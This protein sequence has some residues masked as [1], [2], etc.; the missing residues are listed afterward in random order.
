MP[1]KPM[2]SRMLTAAGLGLMVACS[3]PLLSGAGG[4]IRWNRL[5]GLYAPA[6]E[7]LHGHHTP[8]R[9]AERP[10][11]VRPHPIPGLVTEG[12]V[13]SILVDVRPYVDRSA[14]LGRV[15]I[16]I[17]V[18]SLRLWGRDAEFPRWPEG[19][20]VSRS[21]LSGEEMCRTL[22]DHEYFTRNCG[23]RAPAL[24]VQSTL[25]VRV[26]ASSDG[27]FV[28]EEMMTH[29]AKL[30]QVMGEVGMPASAEVRTSDGYVG[31]LREVIQDDAARLVT[32]VEF[33]FATSGLSLYATGKAP[34]TNRFGQQ[35]TFDRMADQLL[36]S[37]PGTTV[38][39]GAHV[40]YALAVLLR[41]DQEK[42]LLTEATRVRIRKH[43]RMLSSALERCQAPDGSWPW[44]WP[45]YCERGSDPGGDE[46]E[47][48]LRLTMTATGHHLEWI[49]IAP[50]DCRP[51]RQAIGKAVRYTVRTWPEFMGELK[52]DWHLYTVASH[53]ARALWLISG[54]EPCRSAAARQ[55]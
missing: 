1:I 52:D 12:E 23:M 48:R 25:G 5:T 17:L 55:E 54:F 9:V 8:F 51:S 11:V 2:V 37:R 47:D 46:E 27:S 41:V 35:Y 15:P 3:T 24:L 19:I 32:G 49:A 36:G 29:F 26:L 34:W 13:R 31:T 28:A 20:H 14:L 39:G 40:P 16:A 53:A 43:F 10:A 45:A 22:L 44:R 50:D 7:G 30:T 4:P 38:C 18:H 21:A 33:E 42:D 6:P